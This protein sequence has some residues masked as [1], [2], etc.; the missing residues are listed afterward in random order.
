MNGINVKDFLKSTLK[1]QIFFQDSILVQS[2]QFLDKKI[3]N[4]KINHKTYLSKHI[5]DISC[6]I[7]KN[8]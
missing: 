5:R 6:L 8:K 1:I 4:N 2:F 7:I 3:T